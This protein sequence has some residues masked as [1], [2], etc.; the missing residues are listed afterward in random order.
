MRIGFVVNQ[1]PKEL[2]VY[3]TTGLALN[4]SEMGHEVYYIGIGDLTYTQNEL[5]GAHARKAPKR[6][7]SS[8]AE[9]FDTIRKT[10]K[11]LITSKDLDILMLRND[12]SVD[13]ENRPWA[14]NAGVVFGQLAKSQGVL[15]LNDP[16]TLANALNKMY[17]QYFPKSVRPETIITRNLDDIKAFYREYNRKIILKPLQGSGGRNVFLVNEDQENLNQIVDAIARD[18]FVVAQEYLR[19]AE[20][21]D[22][23][24]FLLDGE[25]I[26]VNGK[27][28]GIHRTQ[29]PN[30]IRSNVH[31]GASIKVPQITPSM[32]EL[33][34]EVKS[35]LQQDGMFFT[36]L[37]IVGNKLMEINVF[38]PGGVGN[39]GQLQGV[40]FFE[41]IIRAMERKLEERKAS[42]LST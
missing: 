23:R 3:T 27:T 17:F 7:Y 32:L 42:D 25:P 1:I 14:Q 26:V 13:F 6:Y 12:P 33:V 31:Q 21:G 29:A 40:N 38:S 10:E 36:G 18:G 35:K 5:M 2:A 30:D 39:A 19:D 41:P 37:D 11:E 15:V 28:A 20:Q 4:A 8:N 24:L 9:F 34:D 22:V 16:D